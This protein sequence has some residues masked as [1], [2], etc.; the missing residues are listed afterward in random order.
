MYT[1]KIVQ[2]HILSA[3]VWDKAKHAWIGFLDTRD[4]VSFVVFQAEEMEKKHAPASAGM[5]HL[6]PPPQ[7]LRTIF[8]A[9]T[10]FY[11][12]PADGITTSCEY[13]TRAVLLT[14]SR[15][16]SQP[17]W[18]ISD[19]AQRNKFIPVHL[20][21]SLQKVAEILAG[22]GAH[23]VPVVDSADPSKVLD[24][25]SQST[26]INFFYKHVRQGLFC[27]LFVA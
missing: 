20:N 2:H 14:M 23:R 4:L 10:K 17:G 15:L 9:A 6:S 27:F 26:L 11:H 24:V 1:Q 12:D 25:I 19:L 16:A 8:D 22:G 3:P 13:L 18:Y 7:D 21:D 5:S